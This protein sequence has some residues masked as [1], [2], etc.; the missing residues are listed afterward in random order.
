[1]KRPNTAL[2]AACGLLVVAVFA[3]ALP[4]VASTTAYAANCLPALR[5][6]PAPRPSGAPGQQQGKWNTA[7]TVHAST[8][9]AVGQK[10]NIA[11]RG[12]V[13]ALATAMQESYLRNLANNN[14]AYPEVVRLSMAIPHD[15]V[16]SDHDSVGLF[17]Q[18]PIEG[19]GSWGTVRELMTPSVS[20]TKFYA[21]LN[22][23]HGWQHM[24][25]TDAAQAVQ[26]S[27]YPDAYQKHE[28]AAA[29]LAAQVA[30]TASIDDLGGGLPG[31]ECGLDG[32]PP[33]PVG[34][35]GWVQP[36]R[37]AVVSGFRTASRPNHD[38]VDL[39]A[40]R[41]TPVRAAAAGIVQVSTCNSGNGNCD[42]DGSPW[43]SGCGWYVD[44]RHAG[45]VMTRY[46]HMVRQ[47]SVQIGQA[48]QAG[49]VIGFVGSSGNSSGPHLHYETHVNGSEI[50]P[51]S[52]HIKAG[53]PLG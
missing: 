44:I 1:M 14:P 19:D 34:P 17:Q 49:Q 36:V 18:R 8:I 39:G 53:A 5:T 47:P 26:K 32:I 30:G 2:A 50:D 6:G 31:A 9:V 22:R 12:W 46:C 38:G 29:A 27:A 25:L 16:A 48:V 24:R 35:G 13:I 43:I 37:A 33:V 3:V 28:A 10:M 15:G 51:V 45:N 42:V 11:P 4:M 40:A 21:A 23:V 7:H 41:H 20:A 52:Y